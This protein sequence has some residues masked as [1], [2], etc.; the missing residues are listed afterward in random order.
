[1]KRAFRHE[2]LQ[3]PRGSS[4]R[5]GASNLRRASFASLVIAFALAPA[6]LASHESSGTY[7]IPIVPFNDRRPEERVQD[8]VIVPPQGNGL[9]TT[10]IDPRANVYLRAQIDSTLAWNKAFDQFAPA[11]MSDFEV[12]VFVLGRDIIPP[13][14]VPPDAIIASTEYEGVALAATFKGGQ[15]GPADTCIV[16][17]A[18]SWGPTP[19]DAGSFSYSTMWNANAHEFGHCLGLDHV[20]DQH[21]L[22]DLMGAGY[23]HS[24]GG[25]AHL[26]CPSNLDVLGVAAA[27]QHLY[28]FGYG[29][30]EVAVPVAQYATSA[31]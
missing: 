11:F 21:P 16:V 5:A 3:A 23:P 27:V 26:H 14:A 18:L 20:V 22:H 12:R 8:V 2:S 15:I 6:A 31:C 28:G 1:M 24:V 25:T 17:D 29:P 10:W 9:P 13:D 30:N 4:W 7:R 19:L